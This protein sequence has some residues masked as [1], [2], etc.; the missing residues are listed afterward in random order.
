MEAVRS[1]YWNFI[2]ILGILLGNETATTLATNFQNILSP[3]PRELHKMVCMDL[4]LLMAQGGLALTA[5]RKIEDSLYLKNHKSWTPTPYCDLEDILCCPNAKEGWTI[6]WYIINA[7]IPTCSCGRYFL[8]WG[9]EGLISTCKE[10]LPSV[11]TSDWIHPTMFKS[12]LK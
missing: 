5:R 10:I 4:Y 7:L 9:K 1:Y 11:K 6:W 3:D 2:R 12:S 8:I